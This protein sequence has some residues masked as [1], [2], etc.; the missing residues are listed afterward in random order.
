MGY[1]V[2]KITL[3]QEDKQ[4]FSE[5]GF[6]KLKQLFT[7]EAT[8][9]LR[10]LTSNSHQMKNPPRVYSGEFSKIGYDVE[11]TVTHDI[12][13]STN[14]QYVMRQLAHNELTFMQGIAF[15]IKANQKGFPWHHDIYSFCYIRPEDLGYTLWIPLDPIN[16][17]EQHGGLAYVSCQVY[18]AREY[19]NFIYKLVQ[20]D[21]F[22]ELLKTEDLKN[23]D[24]QFADQM[25][26]FLLDNNKLEEDFEVG[27]ALLLDKCIWHKSYPLKAGPL[28]SRMA[29]VMRFVDSQSRHSKVFLE[30]TYSLIEA[31]S[32]DVQS[33]LGYKM[34]NVL[35]DGEIIPH[36]FVSLKRS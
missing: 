34:A 36:N 11:E 27:D 20:Q 15:E 16:T 2:N 14:F 33:D 9:K 13:S 26:T 8:D 23:Y 25:E 6:I 7:S 29:Y 4:S 31:T 3:S 17:K 19:F 22:K 12:Y 30:G 10:K 35:K 18:S 24:F 1:L 5:N 28:P 21:K 32:N